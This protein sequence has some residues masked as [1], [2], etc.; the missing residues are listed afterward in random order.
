MTSDVGCKKGPL[1]GRRMCQFIFYSSF[2]STRSD[3]LIVFRLFTTVACGR[4]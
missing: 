1:G 4:C 3:N 2:V